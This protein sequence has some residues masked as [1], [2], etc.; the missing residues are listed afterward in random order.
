M[1]L[2]SKTSRLS[3]SPP[4]SKSLQLPLEVDAKAASCR[5]EWFFAL[6]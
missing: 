4:L 5:I 2:N 1:L 6:D 3:I